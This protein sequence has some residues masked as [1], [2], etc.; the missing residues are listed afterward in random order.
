MMPLHV[1]ARWSEIHVV[2]ASC[3]PENHVL[4]GIYAEHATSLNDALTGV[5]CMC[6]FSCTTY[7]MIEQFTYI[8]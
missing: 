4:A 3:C 6:D 2:E 8:H 5:V 7:R 1:G